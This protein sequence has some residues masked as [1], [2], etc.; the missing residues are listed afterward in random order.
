MNWSE[1]IPLVTLLVVVFGG[2]GLFA[3]HNVIK[4]DLRKLVDGT[5]PRIHE[6]LDGLRSWQDRRDGA[7]AERRRIRTEANGVVIQEDET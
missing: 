2:G 7:T 1:H 6:R 3:Q 5:I 4:R